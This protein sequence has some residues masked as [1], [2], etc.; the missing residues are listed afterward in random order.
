M[1][2]VWQS[3]IACIY[4]AP[5]YPSRSA[6]RIIHPI[7]Q[8][9]LNITDITHLTLPFPNLNAICTIYLTTNY[10]YPKTIHIINTIHEYTIHMI[11]HTGT[12]PQHRS[13]SISDTTM[14]LALYMHQ[15]SHEHYLNTTHITHQIP[16][17]SSPQCYPHSISDTMVLTMLFKLYAQYHRL[18]HHNAIHVTHQIPQYHFLRAIHTYL[19]HHT[20]LTT[21]C[22]SV[23][24]LVLTTIRILP[25]LT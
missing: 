22:S 23:W 12:V 9:H 18:A 1:T 11:Y 24:S 8:H 13:H 10:H 3:G 17:Y 20:I 2:Y 15:T 7:P 14:L 5:K 16:Q 4:L 25:S 21:T 19:Y 6:I